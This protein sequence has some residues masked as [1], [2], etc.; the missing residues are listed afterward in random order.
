MTKRSQAGGFAR[1]SH[2]QW[3]LAQSGNVIHLLWASPHRLE[4]ADVHA[5]A[6]RFTSHV[7]R[8]LEAESLEADGFVKP[9]PAFR[10][11]IVSYHHQD[12]Q[13]TAPSDM[14]PSFRTPLTDT[15]RPSLEITC[16]AADHPDEHG[17][18]SWLAI[19][20]AHS[21]IEGADVANITR[22]PDNP[23]APRAPREERRLGLGTRIAATLVTPAAWVS[24]QVIALRSSGRREDCGF[25][26]LTLDRREVNEAARR[27]G[28]SQRALLFGLVLHAA[29]RDGDGRRPV[30]AAIP[31][32][33][34]TRVTG[35]DDGYF[36]VRV[37]AIR[38]A[39]PDDL[40]AYIQG[41][42]ETLSRRS[43]DGIFVH[44]LVMRM[45]GLQRR[46]H[47]AAPALVP[48]RVFDSNYYDIV[49]T[50]VPPLRSARLSPR[51]EG[52]TF[53]GGTMTGTAATCAFVFDT[54]HVSL[55]FWAG[56]AIAARIDA[57]ADAASTLGMTPHVWG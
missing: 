1:F 44:A 34:K 24:S 23:D 56:P 40:A 35:E 38:Y 43:R 4:E 7:P 13:G 10:D 12:T 20:L 30:H 31:F 57:L 6:D 53:M 25:L 42:E 11:G 33:P 39:G 5:I 2:L 47:R 52:A 3:Y 22:A 48:R 26:R 45:M 18:R 51:L 46:I 49:L 14:D 36:D 55:T 15:G 21:A 32:L 54:D 41:L 9:A 29:V 17:V 27:L 19:K 8:L 28:V 16:H 37:D 50:M